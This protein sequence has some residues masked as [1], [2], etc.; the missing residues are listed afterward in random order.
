LLLPFWLSATLLTT[1]CGDKDS[2]GPA[3]EV[4]L[5]ETTFVVLVNP[6][7]NAA[8]AVPV[9]APGTL[10]SVEVS[11]GS[12]QVQAGG[13]G[14]AVLNRI[15]AGS[16]LLHFATPGIAASVS[17]SI[18]EK[19]LHEVAVALGPQSG[20][21]IMANVRYAF[22]GV[23]VEITPSTP[24]AQV[25][26]QLASSNII[27]LLRRGIY[28][29]NIQFTGSNVTLF[30]AGV[31]GGEVTIEGN[32]TIEGSSNRIRGARIVGDLSVSGSNAGV[33]FSRVTGRFSLSGSGA[34]LLNNAFCGPVVLGGSNPTVLGNAG[35]PPLA[36]PS[37]GC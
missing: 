12:A 3:L 9:P 21:G 11:W 35:L 15:A 10:R 4:N 31:S 13:D 23:V 14:I 5:G 37:G 19:D 17:T 7:V 16:G 6:V 30:G 26:A 34:V 20:A 25:N 32:V 8:N 24:V 18:A 36:A 2:T 28:R 1:G 27:V 22:G 29:G 33:S